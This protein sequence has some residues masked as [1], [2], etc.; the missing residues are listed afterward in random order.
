[1]PMEDDRFLIEVDRKIIHLKG[2]PVAL[3]EYLND[4][5]KN[6]SEV[7]AKY[8]SI[9]EEFLFTDGKDNSFLREVGLFGLLSRF[10]LKKEKYLNQALKILHSEKEDQDVR[11]RSAIGIGDT[12]FGER[13]KDLLKNLMNIY[14]YSENPMP[15]KITA[16]VN[17]LKIYGLRPHEI[18]LRC[19][20]P[21][22]SSSDSFFEKNLSLFEKELDEI[23]KIIEE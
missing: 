4:L 21:M 14:T 9:F 15:L 2:K 1:M 6:H 7:A 18:N 20:I 17:L 12:Y 16:F 8:I 3:A 22:F 19:D 13:R 5:S 23:K 11:R 10:K